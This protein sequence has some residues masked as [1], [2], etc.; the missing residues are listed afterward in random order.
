MSDD[1]VHRAQGTDALNTRAAAFMARAEV[2]RLMERP[3]DADEA[4]AQALALYSRRGTLLLPRALRVIARRE[5]PL[6]AS[7]PDSFR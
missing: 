6:G 7:R 2:L 5:A 1:A 4:A 3:D